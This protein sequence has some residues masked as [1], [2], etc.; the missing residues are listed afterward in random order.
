MTSSAQKVYWWLSSFIG[1]F[2]FS[3]YPS[4]IIG[5]CV[6][7]KKKSLTYD[8]TSPL[9]GID[10]QT[11]VLVEDPGGFFTLLNFDKFVLMCLQSLAL[12]ILFLNITFNDH[13]TG[14]QKSV[15]Y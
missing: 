9:K 14:T 13:M 11:R 6:L 4:R 1:V 7:V 5:N 12:R 15:L 10:K 3:G 8:Y 2:I